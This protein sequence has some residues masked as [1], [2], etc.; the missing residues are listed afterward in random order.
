MRRLSVRGRKH[1]LGSRTR[2]N[3]M[4]RNSMRRRRGMS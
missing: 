2:N 1:E 3:R 4:R